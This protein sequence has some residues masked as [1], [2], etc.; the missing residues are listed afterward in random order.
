MKTPDLILET[1]V[2]E[3]WP[4]TM[5]WCE[6]KLDEFTIQKQLEAAEDPNN[7]LYVL[8]GA[9]EAWQQELVAYFIQQGYAG[10]EIDV[11]IL[12]HALSGR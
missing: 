5:H 8:A 1:D 7:G 9:W 6:M 11:F 12:R 3:D 4:R 10:T 2:P